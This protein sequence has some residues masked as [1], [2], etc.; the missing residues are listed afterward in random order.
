[1]KTRYIDI[2]FYGGNASQYDGYTDMSKL[3]K[4]NNAKEKVVIVR[5]AKKVPT[6]FVN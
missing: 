3:A 5:Q 4:G 1:M 6:K 2:N